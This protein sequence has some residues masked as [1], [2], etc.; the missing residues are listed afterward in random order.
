[1]TYRV[2]SARLQ[3]RRSPARRARPPRW[4]RQAGG[5]CGTAAER[6][7]VPRDPAELHACFVDHV[8][9]GLHVGEPR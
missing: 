9:A 4:G 7:V 6:D 2:G 3:Q 5:P 1:M 8:F